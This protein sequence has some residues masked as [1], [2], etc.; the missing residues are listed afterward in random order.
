MRS[1]AG[2]VR[3]RGCVSGGQEPP[4]WHCR[5]PAAGWLNARTGGDVDDRAGALLPHIRRDRLAQPQRGSQVDIDHEPQHV[6]S[7]GLRVSLTG[8]ADRVHQ[9]VRRPDLAGYPVHERRRRRRRGSQPSRDQDRRPRQSRSLLSRSWTQARRQSGDWS[10]PE[11][12]DPITHGI[13]CRS[14]GLILLTRDRLPA[15]L[16]HPVGAAPRYRARRLRRPG[17]PAGGRWSRSRG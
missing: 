16:R 3:C 5:P 12:G 7:R 17:S 4:C 2:A 9:H 13:L 10:S 15:V 1:L 6:G 8:R 14:H 11:P